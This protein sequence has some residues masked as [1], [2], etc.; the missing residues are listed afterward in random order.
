L[1]VGTR[2]DAAR[3][4]VTTNNTA[5]LTVERNSNNLGFMPFG[6][7][8]V[9]ALTTSGILD[10]SHAGVCTISGTAVLSQS[11]PLASTV[12]GAH[13]VFR[14]AS[15]Q[16]HFLTGS[17]EAAGTKVFSDLTTVGSKLTLS[18]TVGQSVALLGDG[19]SFLV[20]GARSGSAA[21]TI[22]GT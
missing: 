13:F 1:S 14:V 16:A 8:A 17:Q 15:N 18:G 4:V 5:G 10:A 19:V 11:M 9:V 21:Y 2:V 22:S 12:P 20:V 6:V 7:D 3:G